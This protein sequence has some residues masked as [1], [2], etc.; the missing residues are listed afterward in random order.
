MMQKA[1]DPVSDWQKIEKF[2][3]GIR[4]EKLQSIFVSGDYDGMTF[5]KFYNDMHEKYRRLVALKQIKPASILKR[6][7]SQVDTDHQGRRG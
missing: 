5:T 2:M 6:K 1:G 7:I 4:C 3:E